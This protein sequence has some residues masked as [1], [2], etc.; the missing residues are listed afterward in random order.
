LITLKEPRRIEKAIIKYSVVPAGPPKEP[1]PPKNDMGN[2]WVKI[3]LTG[4]GCY[5]T[6][7]LTAGIPIFEEPLMSIK[8]IKE[9]EFNGGLP[10]VAQ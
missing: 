2:L 1:K 10:A 4:L 7:T 9:R 6:S 5:T 3:D 8:I